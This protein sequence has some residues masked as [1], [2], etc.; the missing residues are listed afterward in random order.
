MRTTLALLKYLA[1]ALANALPGG[2][3]VA[4][5]FIEVLPEVAK[6]AWEWWSKD[7]RAEERK[8]DVEA[9]AQ[10]GVEQVKLEVAEIVL[11]YASDKPP[12]VQQMMSLYLSQVPSMVRKSLRRPGDPTGTTVSPDREPKKPEDILA[13]LP[14]MPPRF[15]PG[16]RPLPSVD[17]ELV[18]LLGV[19]GF[20]EVW[21][22]RN[23]YMSSMP[24]AALKFC[25]NTVAA[26]VLRNEAV[27]LNQVMKGR[28][29][30][31][32]VELHQTYLAAE[33]PCLEYEYVE[34]G[35][36]AG[37]IFE[38][39]HSKREFKPIQTAEVI[40]QL[41]VIVGSAHRSNP[42][43]VHRDLKP[44][45]ILVRN[46]ADNKLLL[47][48]A[49]FG[50]G[51]AA[52]SQAVRETTIG[53]SQARFLVSA[54][55]GA[56][57]PLYASP[58]QM[59]GG[60]PDPRDD[61]FAI[62]VIWY[63]M[64]T[65][66]LTCGRPGG[67][68]WRMRLAERGVPADLSDLLEVCF[69][70]NP[71]DR[72]ADAVVLAERLKIIL[73]QTALDY[74]NQANRH[75]GNGEWDQA[76]ADFTEAIRLNA[77]DAES[78]NRRGN[79]FISKEDYDSAIADFTKAIQL[80]PQHANAY[81][82]R[83]FAQFR[84]GYWIEAIDDY[85][86]AI[87]LDPQQADA[88][89]KLGIVYFEKDDFQRAIVNF[90][91]AIR[92]NSNNSEAY[93]YLG[94][95]C[96]KK[97]KTNR[98]IN[99]YTE[100][101]RLNPNYAEAHRD[102]A[103]A[104]ENNEK[105]GKAIADYSAYIRLKPNDPQG[106]LERG[107]V[108]DLIGH[109][110]R[111]LADYKEAIRLNPDDKNTKTRCAGFCKYGDE[112]LSLDEAISFFTVVRQYFPEDEVTNSE[113]EVNEEEC[114][115]DCWSQGSELFEDGKYADAIILFA[116][117]IQIQPEN[118]ENR[119]IFAVTACRLNPNI[120]NYMAKMAAEHCS[121]IGDDLLVSDEYFDLAIESYSEAID[122]ESENTKY[123]RKRGEAYL[124]HKEY[125][126]AIADFT[127]AIRFNSDDTITYSNRAKAYRELGEEQKALNDERMAQSLAQ[128]NKG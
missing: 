38:W 17:W 114:A 82:N 73:A 94:L 95:I 99:H 84:K 13:F 8:A 87:R 100:A 68:R 124:R 2:P 46:S 22:A 52:M 6:D 63:Q 61:V 127:E 33:T 118:E 96:D 70:D 90:N 42:P 58:Q 48:V 119:G 67:S 111:S 50:I 31:G 76:I 66:D 60:Q 40:F 3:L 55:Q 101:I 34:G 45:N 97:L 56:C 41:A 27:I 115:E 5:L 51:G 85:N 10:A 98:A 16:D 53:V 92:F 74:L 103:K 126:K 7:R 62:G 78:Y 69:E 104:Y 9:I 93:Y 44:A 25:L 128:A 113:D 72:P 20:G 37:L 49:D 102:R 15:K 105:Y 108:F 116:K 47:K 23:P 120:S 12:D 57:T 29:H 65:G 36:L 86:Q 75:L 4:D 14:A 83:G 1:K 106:Y 35:D 19:G 109:Y 91:M 54:V 11:E 121:R 26:K 125:D 107:K 88:Y 21:K 79:A 59:H 112:F 43:M 18:E 110:H 81:R 64:L 80:N 71:N 39:H 77:D 123:L 117:A 32:I 89:C 24:P 28:K 30:P 122:L